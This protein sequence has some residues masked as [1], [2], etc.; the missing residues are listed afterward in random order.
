MGILDRRPH[1]PP[2][3]AHPEEA[4]ATIQAVA[5]RCMG[6]LRHQIELIGRD[7]EVVPGVR[8]IPAP[9]HTPGHLAVLVSSDGHDLLNLGDAA[10]H[11]LHLEQPAWENGFDLAA[12]SAVA[13]RSRLLEFAVAEN[14]HVMA[15][16]FPFSSVGRVCA[17]KPGAW[18]WTPG[19]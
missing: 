2:Q 16:H 12:D 1:R 8:A 14:M 17:S 4:K 7:T 19:W 6:P 18:G 5:R 10:V 9:G 11:P 15:F 13:T 3:P